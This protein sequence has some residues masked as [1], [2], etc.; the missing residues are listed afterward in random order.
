MSITGTATIVIGPLT[1]TIG[2]LSLAKELLTK[3][4]IRL[5]TI[6]LRAL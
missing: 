3:R 4:I 2:L 6:G 5:S 1:S